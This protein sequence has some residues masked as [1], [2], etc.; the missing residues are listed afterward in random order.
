MA[1]P[2]AQTAALAP[3]P[4][5]INSPIEPPPATPDAA[6]QRLATNSGLEF[7]TGTKVSSYGDGGIPDPTIGFFEWVIVSPTHLAL[8]NGRHIGDTDVM[9]LP[10]AVAVQLFES[11]MTDAKIENPLSAFSMGWQKNGFAFNGTW[12]RAQGADYL[13][14]QQTRN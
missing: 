14:V 1:Q 11:K 10:L 13:I 9:T 7:S 8:P 4:A 5:A 12:V 3:T 6:L 2:Q